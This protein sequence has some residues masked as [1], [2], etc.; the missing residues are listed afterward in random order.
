MPENTRPIT[1]RADRPPPETNRRR[2]WVILL[3]VLLLLLGASAAAGKYWIIPATARQRFRNTV[4]HY[5]GGTLQIDR[6]EGGYSSPIRALG[7]T[8]RDEHGRVWVRADSVTL[9]YTPLPSISDQLCFSSIDGLELTLHVDDGKCRPPVRNIPDFIRW[10]EEQF[11]IEQF[12]IPSGAVAVRYNGKPSGLWDGF[13]FDCRRK[14]ETGKYTLELTR[15]GSSGQ[16]GSRCGSVEAVVEAD[17]PN[18]GELVYDGT[19]TL[20]GFKAED[21]LITVGQE[22][23]VA[24]SLAVLPAPVGALSVKYEFSGKGLFEPQAVNGHG[25]LRVDYEPGSASS[26]AAPAEIE[27]DVEGNVVRIGKAHFVTRVSDIHAEDAGRVDLA[28]GKVDLSMTSKPKG[29]LMVTF[30][31]F[32]GAQIRMFATKTVLIRVTGRW[33]V[34]GKLKV[35]TYPQD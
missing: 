6:M 30:L 23:L 28:T 15:P 33:D 10:L 25:R 22:R 31:R 18:G 9:A 32:A 29:G 2:R 26:G 12:T 27:F 5:W 3:G 20:K 1:L 4:L 21:L 8:L 34:P 19:L 13:A 24:G 17:W 16:S 7:V 35:R 11:S 14:Q